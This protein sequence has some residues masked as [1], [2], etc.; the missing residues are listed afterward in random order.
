MKLSEIRVMIRNAEKRPFVVRT[1]A[2]TTYKV[3]HRDFAIV[4]LDTLIIA[5]S[6]DQDLGGRSFVFCDLED[7]SRLEFMRKKPKVK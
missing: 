3:T 7:I 1:D 5:A 6:P 2:G 4:G